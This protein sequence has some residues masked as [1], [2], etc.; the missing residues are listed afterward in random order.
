MTA[1]VALAVFK[2]RCDDQGSATD[3]RAIPQQE[4]SRERV[5]AILKAASRQLT[6]Y[7]FDALNTRQI[8][9]A[10]K[11]PPGLLYH[12]FPNKAAIVTQLAEQTV[13]PLR[14]E[15]TQLLGKA[16]AGSWR[17]ATSQFVGQPA[18]D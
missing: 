14:H 16:K 7:G 10:A 3:V 9:A 4:R 8:A 13:Q 17:G 15:L 18:A 12:Y 5:A 11:L 6:K 1:V 2:L